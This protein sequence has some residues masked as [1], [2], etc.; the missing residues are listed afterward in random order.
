MPRVN[1]PTISSRGVLAGSGFDGADPE[2]GRFRSYLLGALKH[3]LADH[4]EHARRLKRGGG[5]APDSLDAPSETD[6]SPGFESA[7][8]PPSPAMR[9]S[10]TANGR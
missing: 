3:F 7:I 10:S 1:W 8:Q 5:V 2:R 4:H 9:S 6:T